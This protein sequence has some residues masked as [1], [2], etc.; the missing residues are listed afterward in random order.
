MKNYCIG[1]YFAKAK[2]VAVVLK[3]GKRGIVLCRLCCRKKSMH[4][5]R[6]FL[7][8]EYID[9]AFNAIGISIYRAEA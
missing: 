2:L 1:L 5:A 4:R 7:K 6:P 9:N 8:V 3:I